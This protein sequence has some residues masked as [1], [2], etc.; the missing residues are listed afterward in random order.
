MKTQLY[1]K[2]EKQAKYLIYLYVSAIFQ[3]IILKFTKLKYE[4][5][6]FIIRCI[7]QMKNFFI[8]DTILQNENS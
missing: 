3:I 5:R 6:L 4:K 2:V 7:I 8:L 1:F